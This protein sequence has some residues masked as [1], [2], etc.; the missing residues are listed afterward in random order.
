MPQPPHPPG[1]VAEPRVP[2]SPR[3]ARSKH[4]LGT[5]PQ[6]RTPPRV[7]RVPNPPLH[8]LVQIGIVEELSAVEEPGAQVTDAAFH[9]AL[10]LSPVRPARPDAESPVRREASELLVQHQRAADGPSVRGHHRLHL[11]EQ[12]LRRY[13]PP[14]KPNARSSP[15]I[16][17]AIVCVSKNSS[18]IIRE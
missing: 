2:D 5:L 14:K 8:L 16:T 11:V 9:L 6:G 10:G 4:G 1:T 3:S 13:P 7:R 18:H 17:V 15:V 12:Q